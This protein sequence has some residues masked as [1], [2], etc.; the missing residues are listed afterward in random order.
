MLDSDLGL[1]CEV[2]N[3]W[4]HTK[5][6]KISDDMLNFLEKN[7]GTHWY[8]KTCNKSMANVL[9]TLAKMQNRQDK[10]EKEIND[11]R[12]DLKKEINA[13]KKSFDDSCKKMY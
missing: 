8:C 11:L 3:M 2:C 4:Y 6:Q 1:Q 10:L 5:C 9:Q 13:M 7:E 12:N